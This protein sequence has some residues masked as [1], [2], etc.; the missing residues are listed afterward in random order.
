ASAI[1]YEGR[2]NHGQGLPRADLARLLV[3][4]DEESVAITVS[5][6][7]RQEGYLVDIAMSGEEAVSRLQQS[8]Y[9][10]VLTDLHMEGMDGISVLAEVHQHAPYAITIVLTGFASLESAIAAMRQGAYDYLIK[11]CNIDDMK[12]TIQRGLEHRRLI[13]AEKQ[14]RENL[15]QLN[16]M[17]ER[18]VEERTAELMRLNEELADA[19]RAKD[20][21]LASLS[22]EL[23]TPLTPIL[24]WSRLLRS[25]KADSALV[26]QGLDAIERN[27]K[28]Q[29]RLIDDLLDVSRIVMGKLSFDKEPVDLRAVVEAAIETVR[30][31][32]N[33]HNLELKVQL[34]DE[35]AVVQGA[36][37]RLQQI[38]WNYLTNAIKFTQSGGLICVELRR[39]GDE[40]QVSVSDT[41]AGIAPDFLPHV[42][43][44]FKQGD[45]SLTRR[46]GGLGL[47]LAI[48]RKLAELHGGW[49]RAES[50]GLG[51]GT[52]FTFALPCTTVARAVCEKE[53][54]L[55][56]YRMNQC[57]LIV[58]DSLDTLDMMQALFEAMGCSVLI[59][60]SAEMALKLAA[61]EPPAIIVSDIGMPNVNGYEFL[62]R[63]R[64]IPGLEN[65][66]AIAVSGYA[67]EEDTARALAAGFSAHLAKPIDVDKLVD[68]IQTLSS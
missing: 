5:E 30:D 65:V 28:L 45:E 38:V 62:A 39:A 4:D 22:H 6:V 52:R 66:P 31:K 50:E 7:L 46:H 3:I 27:A 37:V 48:V 32:A 64:Q 1:N 20:V 47:G 21:F 44:P 26:A 15:E 17:L 36:P 43:E 19:N 33:S 56:A 41:G 55:S 68:L 42:F 51:K 58:E 9:D 13:L 35:P 57:V 25:G 59:A 11:P 23:R 63:L 61:S 2:T 54:S 34:P 10:L 18:R 67:T 24:G 53:G 8:Q 29:A 12:H 40:A 16:R 60:D 49:V 14:A